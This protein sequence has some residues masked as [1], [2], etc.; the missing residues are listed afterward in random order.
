MIHRY[1]E[2]KITKTVVI[3]SND[4]NDTVRPGFAFENAARKKQKYI[5]M[6]NNFNFL[7]FVVL[8]V[9]WVHRRLNQSL[10]K[11]WS[12]SISRFC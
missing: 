1:I 3:E 9:C 6:K 4:R 12:R 5:Q 10:Y 7:A 8:R 2:Y 11:G